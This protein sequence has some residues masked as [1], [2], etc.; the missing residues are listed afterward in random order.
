VQPAGF[1]VAYVGRRSDEGLASS[2][3]VLDVRTRATRRLTS[4]GGYLDAWPSWD[5][6]GRHITFASGRCGHMEAWSVDVATGAVR[7]LTRS[8]YGSSAF[9]A[10]RSPDGRRLAVIE[11][12]SPSGYAGQLRVY[13]VASP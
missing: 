12:S 1:Q 9:C 10:R 4:V 6:D 5:A 3:Y 7:Q 8:R 11:G 13:E 2:L